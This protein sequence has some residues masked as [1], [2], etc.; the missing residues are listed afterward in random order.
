MK[1]LRMALRIYKENFVDSL[2]GSVPDNAR[3]YRADKVWTEDL[4]G[5]KADSIATAVTPAEKLDLR[6]PVGDDLQDL[7]NTI[8]VHRALQMLPPVQA[9][10]PRLWTRL[11]H[12][13][14]WRYMRTRWNTER[15]GGNALKTQT[16]IV[17][18]YFVARNESRALLRNG[19]ARLWWYGY[20]THDPDRT[21]PYELTAVLLSSLD[22]TQQ[23][24][25]RSLGRVPPVLIPITLE[26]RA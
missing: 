16:F 19:L 6:E 15:F 13:D 26:S 22:I 11:T 4:P 10:D 12:S 23:I 14:C 20:L 18:R 24:L 7:E 9:R 1:E 2:R 8:I 17:T 25:E 21:N 3:K 5:A